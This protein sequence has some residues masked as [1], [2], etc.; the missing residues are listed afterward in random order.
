MWD[1]NPEIKLELILRERDRIHQIIEN[2]Y[3]LRYQVAAIFIALI[4]GLWTAIAAIVAATFDKFLTDLS[5]SSI[6]LGIGF[7]CSIVLLALWRIFTNIILTETDDLQLIF[8]TLQRYFEHINDKD[9]QLK[10]WD[11]PA[12]LKQKEIV[13]LDE[14]LKELKKYIGDRCKKKYR[15]K[16]EP[17][18]M[19][20]NGLLE[21]DNEAKKRDLLNKIK[22]ENR[23]KFTNRIAIFDQTA[24]SAIIIF[25]MLSIV[26][27]II[28][29]IV[30]VVIPKIPFDQIPT[31]N[32]IELL[33]FMGIII[34][35]L[36]AISLFEK[37]LKPIHQYFCWNKDLIE[38]LDREILK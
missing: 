33:A 27:P 16:S 11:E 8:S 29:F 24:F 19:K 21:S 7:C 22:F 14:D 36:I 30:T 35:E 3:T 15:E 4:S 9:F 13:G 5:Y 32:I 23:F 18:I 12:F 2:R 6:L 17:I 31:T 26:V 25:L 20:I 37:Q 10:I 34:I 28:F 38:S 1:K